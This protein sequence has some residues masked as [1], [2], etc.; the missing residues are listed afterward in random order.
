MPPAAKGSWSP[1]GG[2]IPPSPPFRHIR[3]SVTRRLC[4]KSGIADLIETINII[5]QRHLSIIK[6]FL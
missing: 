5:F 2:I 6:V 3:L 1:L 4:I